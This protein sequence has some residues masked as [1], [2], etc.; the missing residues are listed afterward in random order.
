MTESIPLSIALE[1]YFQTYRSLIELAGVPDDLCDF[2][3]TRATAALAM[4][5]MASYEELRHVLGAVGANGLAHIFP[6]RPD[7]IHRM[8]LGKP[9]LRLVIG[10]FRERKQ[11]KSRKN[12]EIHAQND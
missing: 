3:A 9:N 4:H 1:R 7:A 11:R 5:R 2:E 8:P 12:E 10:D 6:K